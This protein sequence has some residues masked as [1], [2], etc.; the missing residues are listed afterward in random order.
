MTVYIGNA[1]GLLGAEQVAQY[2]LPIQDSADAIARMARHFDTGIRSGVIQVDNKQRADAL[3]ADAAEVFFTTSLEK[4]LTTITRGPSTTTLM[5]PGPG[6]LLPIRQELLPGH[7]E[8]A[9]DVETPTGQAAFADPSGVRRLPQVGEFSERKKHGTDWAGI[10][11]GFGLVEMWQSAQKGGRPVEVQRADNARGALWRFI[12]GLFLKGDATHQIPGFIGNTNCLV[13]YLGTGFQA[14]TDPDNAYLRL[15]IM[16]L[17]FERAAKSY[18]GAITGVIAP[19]KDRYAMQRL[20]YGT[21]SEGAGFLDEALKGFAWLKDV[22]WI[23]GLETAASTGGA[24]WQMWSGD[25]TELWSEM[26]AAPMMFGPFTDGGGLRTSFVLLNHVGGVINR[27]PERIARF[28][29][30]A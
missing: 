5:T 7:T 15:Q 3:A 19:Q 1:P 25:D 21:G 13:N 28:E 30:A 9:Y 29:F 27:R 22:R 12:E 8:M 2:G 10:G 4:I 17:M 20:R 6:Q 18:G 26:G 11:Y 14:L 16:E 24:L 23:D